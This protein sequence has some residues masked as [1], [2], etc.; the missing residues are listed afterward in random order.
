MEKRNLLLVEY[1]Q[2]QRISICEMKSIKY[3]PPIVNLV[4][5]HIEAVQADYNQRDESLCQDNARHGHTKGTHWQRTI[6]Q[7]ESVHGGVCHLN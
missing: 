4:N 6:D 5:R 2:G 3:P 1:H 7:A